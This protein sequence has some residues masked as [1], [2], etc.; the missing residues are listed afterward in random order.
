MTSG[1]ARLLEYAARGTYQDSNAFALAAML[2]KRPQFADTDSRYWTFVLQTWD[3]CTLVFP[4]HDV[5]RDLLTY[6]IPS[7]DSVMSKEELDTELDEELVVYRG[8]RHADFAQGM[9]WSLSR[10]TAEWYSTLKGNGLLESVGDEQHWPD[11]TPISSLL[12]TGRLHLE[13]VIWYFKDR[14]CV[15]DEIVTFP[16]C[17][18]IMD[19]TELKE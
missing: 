12:V 2:A 10:D 7:R 4:Y 14:L 16:E 6:D 11:R 17:V 5:W 19:L 15:A 9:S 3:F 8:I 1:E 18:E 13:D